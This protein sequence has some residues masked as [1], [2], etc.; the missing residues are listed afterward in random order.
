MS[1]RRCA[2]GVFCTRSSALTPP[3]I[4]DGRSRRL[5]ASAQIHAGCL[6]TSFW[7]ECLTDV[8]DVEARGRQPCPPHSHTHRVRPNLRDGER[9]CSYVAKLLLVLGSPQQSPQ[10]P[11]ASIMFFEMT[12]VS[13]FS[14]QGQPSSWRRR[15]MASNQA[16]KLRMS[17]VRQTSLCFSSTAA[18]SWAIFCQMSCSYC[19]SG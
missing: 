7:L 12:D 2:H 15:Q 8:V 1:R 11:Q 9:H 3:H 14:S 6:R 13:L 5:T 16:V 19:S 18:A 10:P 4:Q 17:E